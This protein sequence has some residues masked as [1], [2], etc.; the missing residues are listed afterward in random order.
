MK[1]ETVWQTRYQEL[2]NFKKFEGHCEVPRKYRH[3]PK[4]GNWIMTQR[5]QYRLIRQ[6]KISSITADRK[7][8]LDIIGFRWKLEKHN[9]PSW[10]ERYEELNQFQMQEGTCY[11]QNYL[12]EK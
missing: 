9:T 3:S 8:T 5:S 11:H 2:V 6:G 4:L 10:V 12:E 1:S 7:E